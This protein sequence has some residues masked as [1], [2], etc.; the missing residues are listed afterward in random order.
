VNTKQTT[1]DFINALK[2]EERVLLQATF[3]A[4]LALFLD[5]H[6]Q[7]EFALVGNEA[8]VEI[9]IRAARGYQSV[10]FGLIDFIES[11]LVK[12]GQSLNSSQIY[13]L[14]L[15]KIASLKH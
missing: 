9:S 4:Y 14:I 12:S 2:P 13:S 10:T 3:F 7:T 5:F 6:K 8:E 1:I 11:A 15:Q